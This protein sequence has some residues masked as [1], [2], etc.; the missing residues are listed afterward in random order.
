M[1]LMILLLRLQLNLFFI[2]GFSRTE[3][4]RKSHLINI[5]SIKISAVYN[6]LIIKKLFLEE[7]VK[8]HRIVRRRGS[9]ILHSWLIDGGEIVSLTRRPPFTSRKIPGTHFS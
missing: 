6:K 7:A 9:H 2:N 4:L 5:T 3:R 8:A 1:I